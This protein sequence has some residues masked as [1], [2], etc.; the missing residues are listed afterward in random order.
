[1]LMQT[2]T[3]PY[4]EPG[5]TSFDFHSLVWMRR[6][7][8]RADEWSEV[9][10]FTSTQL[11]RLSLEQIWVEAI[12]AFDPDSGTAILMV[13]EMHP[14]GT[15]QQA[16]I[17]SFR[18]FDLRTGSQ[19][20]PSATGS[21]DRAFFERIRAAAPHDWIEHDPGVPEHPMIDRLSGD[22]VYDGEL[23]QIVHRSLDGTVEIVVNDVPERVCNV[24]AVQW[25]DDALVYEEA[26]YGQLGHPFSGTL[27]TYQ[28]QQHSDGSLTCI[29]WSADQPPLE[30]VYSRP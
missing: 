4:T 8:T 21:T 1:M 6:A 30:L 14:M 18:E 26:C 22:W 2:V 12:H 23:T 17:R 19:L 20:W 15:G 13:A 25:R 29:V 27:T 3:R 16:A 9:A 5:T 11:D 24:R 10:Q 7:A 28:W